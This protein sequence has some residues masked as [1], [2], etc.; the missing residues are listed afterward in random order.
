VRE[1]LPA[2]STWCATLNDRPVGGESSAHKL[3]TCFHSG[4]DSAFMI[5]DLPKVKAALKPL[6]LAG[7]GT[8]I[9]LVIAIEITIF[10]RYS[11]FRA[12]TDKASQSQETFLATED[13]LTDNSAVT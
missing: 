12:N 8:V 2:A 4:Y 13:I 11:Q 3:A 7:L 5:Y 6:P 9:A 1:V 10:D